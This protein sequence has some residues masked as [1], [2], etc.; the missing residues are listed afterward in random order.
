MDVVLCRSKD[1]LKMKA[2]LICKSTQIFKFKTIC[3]GE[4]KLTQ[5]TD[6][7]FALGDDVKLENE[8]RT[9]T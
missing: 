5:K 1:E 6:K 9:F 2:V 7:N 3:D 8:T 4:R